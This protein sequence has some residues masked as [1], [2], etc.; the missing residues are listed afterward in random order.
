MRILLSFLLTLGLLSP[1]LAEPAPQLVV[2]GLEDYENYLSFDPSSR[3]LTLDT[4]TGLRVWDLHS[5]KLLKHLL[6]PELHNSD[7]SP[8]G[9]WLAVGS[10]PRKVE[11]YS[12]TDGKRV[13]EFSGLAAGQKEGAYDVSFSS[14][15]RYLMAAGASKGREAIDMTARVWS[16]GDW[17]PVGQ[18]KPRKQSWNDFCWTPWGEIAQIDEDPRTLL[19]YQPTGFTVRKVALKEEAA[20][21]K[22]EGEE[23]IAFIGTD[24]QRLLRQKLAKGETAARAE[25]VDAYL[26]LGE[27]TMLT[28]TVGDLWTSFTGYGGPATLYRGEDPQEIGK[29]AWAS[30]PP[31]A[32]PNGKLLAIPLRKGVLVLDAEASAREGKLVSFKRL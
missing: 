19:L 17:K 3:F 1:V 12:L 30:G 22:V 21:L 10:R 13:W 8:D 24:D 4:S 15:G 29:L 11:V 16:A 20:N 25:I 31:T 27:E 18:S 2:T 9:R 14:D 6:V 5:F 32:S 7:V 26:S 28:R 23:L